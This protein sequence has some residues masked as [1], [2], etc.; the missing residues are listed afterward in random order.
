M[1]RMLIVALALAFVGVTTTG[2]KKKGDAKTDDKKAAAKKDEKKA[3][4]KKAD[5]KKADKADEKKADDKKAT[6]SGGD[7]IGVP[8]CDEYLSKYEK[9]VSSKVPEAARAAMTKSMQTVRKTWKQAAS[10]DAGKKGLEA[11][12]KKMLEMAK[13]TMAS[14]KCDW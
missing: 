13:K 11:S 9:C 10:T 2:C 7:K 14:Y 6:A 4:E 1:K 5:E 8:S 3:D 12:C